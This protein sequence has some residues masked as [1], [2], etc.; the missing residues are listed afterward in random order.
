MAALGAVIG[1]TLVTGTAA[2]A[3][4]GAAPLIRTKNP[5][6]FFNMLINCFCWSLRLICMMPSLY[7]KCLGMT[8]VYIYIL[9]VL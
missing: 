2:A 6:F 1:N 4:K 9:E 8:F 7:L 3:K 5:A